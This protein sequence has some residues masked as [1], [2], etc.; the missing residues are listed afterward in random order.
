M[1][2]G[3]QIRRWKILEKIAKIHLKRIHVRK[4]GSRKNSCFKKKVQNLQ[5]EE[6]AKL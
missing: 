3:T 5:V 2:G 1:T 6:T 4:N